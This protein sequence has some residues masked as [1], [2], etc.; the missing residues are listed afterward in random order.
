M[1][2]LFCQDP[3]ADKQADALYIHEALTAERLGLVHHLLDFEALSKG[4]VA[5]A[6]RYVPNHKE[7]TLALYRGWTLSSRHYDLLYE[8]LLSRGLRLINTPEQYRHTLYLPE[9]LDIIQPKSPRTV[10]FKTDGNIDMDMLMTALLPFMGRAVIVKDFV[11]SQKHYWHEACY[12]PSSSDRAEVERVVRRF[13]ELQGQLTGGLVFREFADLTPLGEHP[14]T[15]MPL[16]LE[17]RIV[18][19]DAQAIAV[20]RYWDVGGY[21]EIEVPTDEFLPIAQ[22]I[23]SRFF[24]MDVAQKRDNG[25]MIVELGDGQVAGLPSSANQLEGLPASA[26]IEAFYKQLRD[27]LP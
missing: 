18:F 10:W 17:Y 14:Q 2:L 16:S 11:K 1:K 9:A 25:W 27:R 13:I 26:N 23:R 6:V 7:E 15:H 22:H 3:L 8:A 19:L 24:T 20:W 12:I 21:S 4:N 5:R